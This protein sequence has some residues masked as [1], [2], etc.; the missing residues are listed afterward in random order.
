MPIYEYHCTTCGETVEVLQ[1]ASE[2][3]RKQCGEDCARDWTPEAG[4]GKLVRQMALTGGY[5]MGKPRAMQNPD[6][7][8]SC[9]MKPG[10]CGN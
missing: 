2:G 7:C 1:R 3:D 9:G 6:N 5:S 8:G 4:E 10:T